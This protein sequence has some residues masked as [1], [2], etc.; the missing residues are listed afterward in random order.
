MARRGEDGARLSSVEQRLARHYGSEASLTMR[1]KPG[2]GA[3]LEL[4]I[5]LNAAPAAREP[6]KVL[7]EARA[8]RTSPANTARVVASAR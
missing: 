7:T 5:P 8:R 1:T 4:W 6:L 2:L 3:V